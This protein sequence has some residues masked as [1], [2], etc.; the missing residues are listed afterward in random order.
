[1][2]GRRFKTMTDTILELAAILLLFAV[3][4]GSSM[5]LVMANFIHIG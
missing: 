4:L 3:F 5:I 1:M 2:I